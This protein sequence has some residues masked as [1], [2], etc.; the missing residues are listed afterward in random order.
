MSGE[1]G[2][3]VVEPWR[4]RIR[5]ARDSSRKEFACRDEK[6]RGRRKGRRF[7]G[8]G[9]GGDWYAEAIR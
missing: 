5:T 1:R 3:L 8:L 4:R 2:W 6:S 9:P 7:E